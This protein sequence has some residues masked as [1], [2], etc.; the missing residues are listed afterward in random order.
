MWFR[1][2]VCVTFIP[3]MSIHPPE[4][5]MEIRVFAHITL[6]NYEPIYSNYVLI[7]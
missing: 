2:K 7:K 4:Y 1:V 3:Y 5:K 6:E